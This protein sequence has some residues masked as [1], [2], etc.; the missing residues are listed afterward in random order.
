MEHFQTLV[1]HRGHDPAVSGHSPAS[2]A[3]GVMRPCGSGRGKGIKAE[4]WPQ[5]LKEGGFTPFTATQ[6][7]HP[8]DQSK[9]MKPF[10]A[11]TPLRRV[12]TLTCRDRK[13]DTRP[14]S[15]VQTR[16]DLF[17]ANSAR[18][19]AAGTHTL[20]T[21]SCPSW[22]SIPRRQAELL[23]ASL[24]GVGIAVRPAA[25]IL[26]GG[27]TRHQSRR[28]PRPAVY[29]RKRPVRSWPNR[30]RSDTWDT[31]RN[32]CKGRTRPTENCQ[33]AGTPPGWPQLPRGPLGR[34]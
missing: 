6:N 31:A 7:T 12:I 2:G 19:R 11:L 22:P 17:C 1:V 27:S 16:A 5:G 4:G 9:R 32:W 34:W 15:S 23:R 26:P 8:D 30:W 28:P 25:G 3:H 14:G 18:S 33:A 24:D 21:A 29:W 10:I 20:S 13:Y